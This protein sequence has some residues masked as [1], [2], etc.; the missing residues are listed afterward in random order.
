MIEK[1]ANAKASIQLFFPIDPLPLSKYG[2]AG[3]CWQTSSGHPDIKLELEML[4]RSDPEQV[5]GYSLQ[6][7]VGVWY[8]KNE[9]Q[10]LTDEVCEILA[11]VDPDFVSGYK[12]PNDRQN[13]PKKFLAKIGK[14]SCVLMGHLCFWCIF[15]GKSVS[16]ISASGLPLAEHVLITFD[17]VL[18]EQ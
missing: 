9:K 5:F 12:N 7:T 11:Y 17:E 8:N 1:F 3:R 4:L 10:W 6:C 18:K 2:Q 16:E 14:L 15:D 13:D